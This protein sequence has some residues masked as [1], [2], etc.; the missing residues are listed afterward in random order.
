MRTYIDNERDAILTVV[1]IVILLDLIYC[2]YRVFRPIKIGNDD[3]T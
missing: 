3:E 1:L 2:L